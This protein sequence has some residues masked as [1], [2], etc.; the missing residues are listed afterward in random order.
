MSPRSL[1]LIVQIFSCSTQHMY[2]YGVCGS[3]VWSSCVAH[4]VPTPPAA[5]DFELLYTFFDA[6]PAFVYMPLPLCCSRIS[7]FNVRL[8]PHQIPLW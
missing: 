3:G 2:L 8:V 4:V 5:F 6:V 1:S 7:G